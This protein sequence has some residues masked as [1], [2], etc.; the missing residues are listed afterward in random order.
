MMYYYG[1]SGF[2]EKNLK[3]LLNYIKVNEH[4]LNNKKYLYIYYKIKLKDRKIAKNIK[5]K[6]DSNN[7][8]NINDEDLKKLEKKVLKIYYDDFTAE[9]IK[10][11]PPSFF[12][13]LSTLYSSSSIDNE[14]IIFEYVLLNRA[15]NASLSDKNY[16]DF[17]N[18]EEQYLQFKAKK[19]LIEKSDKVDFKDLTKVKGIINVEGY[20]DDGIICPIC[21]ENQKSTICLPCKHFFCSTCIK[22]LIK[23]G[24]CPI[25]RR[26]IKITFDI[27]LKKEDLIKSIVSDSYIF[28]F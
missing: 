25:C 21:F 24:S 22:K 4:L 11:Y 12:Y 17:N 27:N 6:N 20:G 8:D 9:N 10:K 15:A 19:K 2:V 13:I 5:K 26:E 14:D 18:F 3:E 7:K 23:K 1:V 16:L 28:D